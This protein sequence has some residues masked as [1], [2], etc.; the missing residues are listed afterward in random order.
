[1]MVFHKHA[2]ESLSKEEFS[3]IA[4]EHRQLVKFVQELKKACACAMQDDQG[5]KL[6]CNSENKA[7]CAGRFPSYLYHVIDL[8]TRHFIHEEMIMLEQTHIDRDNQLFIKHHKAHVSVLN[9]LHHMIDE[10]FSQIN[11]VPIS[12]LYRGFYTDITTL[13][14]KHD[15]AFDNPFFKMSQSR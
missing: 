5:T 13:F 2:L 6:S 11:D 3:R 4:R 9:K 12:K 10:Y 15:K 8:T 14:D 1:M 7:S